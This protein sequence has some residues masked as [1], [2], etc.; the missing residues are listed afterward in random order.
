MEKCK[1]LDPNDMPIE[2][3]LIGVIIVAWLIIFMIEI[4]KLR[5][6]QRIGEEVFLS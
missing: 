3:W 2:T 5:R 1:D 6:C 4:W